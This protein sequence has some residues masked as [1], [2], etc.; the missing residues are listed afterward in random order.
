MTEQNPNFARSGKTCKTQIIKE[1]KKPIHKII[2][3]RD[4]T[5]FA[6]LKQNDIPD[7]I[8]DNSTNVFK[9]QKLLNFRREH[10]HMTQ[11]PQH[12]DQPDVL[13]GLNEY[14]ETRLKK[15]FHSIKKLTSFNSIPD[16]PDTIEPLN[17]DNI[18]AM[19]RPGSMNKIKKLKNEE[20]KNPENILNKK[21]IKNRNEE[22][23]QLTDI[24][25]RNE[26]EEMKTEE[27]KYNDFED[28]NI[29]EKQKIINE[30]NENIDKNE[31]KGEISEKKESEEKKDK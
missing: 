14:K 27:N 22:K 1:N 26:T 21:N 2:S 25:E 9:A 18:N 8:N 31:Q 11:I 20:A 30:K 19:P 28:E 4:V 6:T 12:I 24:K 29:E 17:E 3:T 5:K 16:L 15:G 7:T 13:L 10:K 23:Q